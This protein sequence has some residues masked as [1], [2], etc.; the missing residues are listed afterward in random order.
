MHFHG[1]DSGVKETGKDE[2]HELAGKCYRTGTESES[3]GKHDGK[4]QKIMK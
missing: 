1:Q 2:N 3:D 4:G